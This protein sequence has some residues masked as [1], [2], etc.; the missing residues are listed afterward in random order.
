MLH[1]A[2]TNFEGSIEAR[3]GFFES[4][5]QAIPLFRV[6]TREVILRAV[7]DRFSDDTL[8]RF[9]CSAKRRISYHVHHGIVGSPVWK[10]IISMDPG[11]GIEQSV[12]LGKGHLSLHPAADTA[13]PE[14]TAD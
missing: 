13:D 3:P 1:T 2:Q 14:P 4:P 6:H 9:S 5:R 8:Q 7:S 11:A 10:R 12:T